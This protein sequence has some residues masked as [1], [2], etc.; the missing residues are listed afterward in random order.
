MPLETR[1]CIVL[2]SRSV[3]FSK[4]FHFRD[5]LLHFTTELYQ[6][7]IPGFFYYIAH[8]TVEDFKFLS[9]VF[10]LAFTCGWTSFAYK[11]QCKTFQANKEHVFVTY[12]KELNH[13]LG[14]RTFKVKIS[15]VFFSNFLFNR[16]LEYIHI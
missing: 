8:C 15:K 14:K 9:K 13:Y 6:L 16:V 5:L 10:S 2:F 4:I 12:L 7:K 3:F 1:L 11:I